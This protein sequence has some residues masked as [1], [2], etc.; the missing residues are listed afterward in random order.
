MNNIITYIY[1]A[2]LVC[3]QSLRGV[4][5]LSSCRHLSWPLEITCLSLTLE[6]TTPAMRVSI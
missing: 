2:V 5:S 6:K 1:A 4:L 3:N